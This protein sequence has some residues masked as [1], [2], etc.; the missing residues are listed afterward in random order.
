ML[1]NEKKELSGLAFKTDDLFEAVDTLINSR[2]QKLEYDQTVEAKIVST[3]QKADGIYKVEY[4]SAIFDAYANDSS[5]YYA[6]EMVYVMIPKGDFTKQK[7]I[8]G[9]ITGKDTDDNTSKT[10]NFK[11]PFDNF[12]GLE[13]LMTNNPMIPVQYLANKPT[14]GLKNDVADAS[15]LNQLSGQN[16]DYTAAISAVEAKMRNLDLNLS[17]IKNMLK[18]KAVDRAGSTLNQYQYTSNQTLL[19]VLKTQIKILAGKYNETI[20]ENALDTYWTWFRNQRNIDVTIP[21]GDYDTLWT[22]ARSEHDRQYVILTGEYN[23]AVENARQAVN[24]LFNNSIY[25][26]SNSNHIW[27]WSRSSQNPVIETKLGIG[28]DFKVLLGNYRPA[29]GDYGLRI[30]ISGRTKPTEEKNSEEVTEEVY[31]K[32]SDMY[33][34]VYAFYE[35]YTQQKI[36]DI[37]H[38]V[39]LNRI[40]IFFWQ[41][42]NFIA[43]NGTYI[44]YQAGGKDLPANI[45][46]SGLDVKLG[47]TTDECQTDRVFLYTYDDVY[48]GY[49]P[50]EDTPRA[51]DE[52]ADRILNFAWVHIGPDGPV[53]VNHIDYYPANNTKDQAAL[54]YWIDNGGA[55]IQ[56]YHFEYG[57]AQDTT[58]L[59]ER[60][61]GASWKYL[62]GYNPKIEGKDYNGSQFS[63][64]VIP[65]IKKAKDKW[66]AV[67]SVG[68]VPYST[69]PLV[70]TNRDTRVESESFDSLNE[71][72]FRILHEEFSEQ[73]NEFN[74]VEDNQLRDFYVYDINGYAI[75]NE[76]NRLYSDIDYYLQVCIRNNDTGEY[77]PM[78]YDPDDGLVEVEFAWPRGRTMI[79]DWN[80]VTLEDLS[81]AE[82]APLL[83]GAS[84]QYN[85]RI[86]DITRKFHINN[87]WEAN[88]NNNT[89]SATVKRR[90]KTYHPSIQFNFGPSSSMGTDYVLTLSQTAPGGSM[91]VKDQQFTIEANVKQKAA[92]KDPNSK[93]VFSW[94]LLSPTVITQSG[95]ENWSQGQAPSWTVDNSNGFLGN[96]IQGYVRN[97]YPPIFKVTVRNAADYP[98]SQ[99]TGFRLA[100][101]ADIAA[102]YVVNSCTER[103]EFKSDGAVP[104]SYYGVFSVQVMKDDGTIADTWPEW[105]MSQM[106]KSGGNWTLLSSPDYFGLKETMTVARSMATNTNNVIYAAGTSNMPNLDGPFSSSATGAC[107]YPFVYQNI[108]NAINQTYDQTI[109]DAL[110]DNSSDIEQVKSDAEY[111]R[112]RRLNDLDLSASKQLPAYKSYQFEP[113]TKNETNAPTWMWED[114]LEKNYYTFIG[115]TVLEGYFKQAVPFTRN[116]YSSTLLNSWD[117]KLFLD[118]DNNAILSQMVSAGTKS[119]VDGTF[120]GV[121]MGNWAGVSDTSLDIPG[122]YGLKDGGQVFGF[123]TDGTGFIGKSGR[124]RIMFDGNQSLISNVDRTSYINLDPIRYHYDGNSIVFDD[125]KGYSQFFLYS[126][127]KKTSTAS[128]LGEDSL[129][130]STYWAKKYM[131]DTLKDYFIVDPNNGILTSGGV[132]ARYGKIGNW[133]ISE[134]GIYQK[135]T[136]PANSPITANRYMY[137]GYPGVSDSDIAAVKSAYA[138]AITSIETRRQLAIN[139]LTANYLM[140]AFQVIGEYYKN[141]FQLDPMHYFNY[142]WPYY[143]FIQAIQST[144]DVINNETP[145]TEVRQILE[146]NLKTYIEAETRSGYHRHYMVVNDEYEATEDTPYTGDSSIFNNF[147]VGMTIHEPYFYGEVLQQVADTNKYPEGSHRT[148]IFNN[149][150]ISNSVYYIPT[151]KALYLTTYYGNTWNS[152]Y[153][154]KWNAYSSNINTFNVNDS[155][156]FTIVHL[157]N[158]LSVA[159]GIYN[160]FLDAYTR[161]IQAGLEAGYA[162]LEEEQKAEYNK[163]K[164]K[165]LTRMDDELQKLNAKYDELLT[166]INN[167]INKAVKALY[168]ADKNRYAIYAGYNPPNQVGGVDPLFTVNWRGYMTARAGKIG[169][170]SPWY[171]SDEGLTQKNNSGTIFLGN[172]NSRSD[173]RGWTDLGLSNDMDNLSEILL[174]N[175]AAIT[176]DANGNN[177]DLRGPAVF[178][179][180]DRGQFAIYAGG[181][182]KV[183]SYDS[184][185]KK[186]M[187]NNETKPTIKFGVRMDGTLYASRG[188]VGGWYIANNML[189]A[190]SPDGSGDFLVLD[191]V[192]GVINLNNAIILEKT[193]VVTLG[194]MVDDGEG[195]LVSSGTINIAGV[196]FKGRNSGQV[197]FSV[198]TYA[199]TASGFG[200]DEISIGTAYNFWGSRMTIG[201]ATISAGQG[202]SVTAAK[203]IN[204]TALLDINDGAATS[205]GVIIGFGTEETNNNKAVAIYPSVE[206]ALTNSVLGTDK[207][208]WDIIGDYVTCNTLDVTQG[209]ISAL[210]MFMGTDSA[211]VATQKWVRAQL[212]DVYAAI[213]DAAQGGSDAGQRSYR[214]ATNLASSINKMIDAIVTFLEGKYFVDTYANTETGAI[215]WDYETS[216]FPRLMMRVKQIT[217]AEDG[218]PVYISDS[219]DPSDDIEGALNTLGLSSE[220]V[221]LASCFI[222][223]N[224]VK[225]AGNNLGGYDGV[226]YSNKSIQTGLVRQI[227]FAEDYGNNAFASAK[228]VDSAT[229][230]VTVPFAVYMDASEANQYAKFSID[231]NHSHQ[232]TITWDDTTG[233]IKISIDNAN[234]Q[235]T[236]LTTDDDQSTLTIST[237]SWFQAR[238]IGTLYGKN[239]YGNDVAVAARVVTSTQASQITSTKVYGTY[240]SQSTTASISVPLT[241]KALDST[242]VLIEGDLTVDAAQAY[243]QGW[244]DAAN[245]LSWYKSGK[246]LY[247]NKPQ[248]Y[249]SVPSYYG[250]RTTSKQIAS[251]SVELDTTYDSACDTYDAESVQG[252]YSDVYT[253]SAYPSSTAGKYQYWNGTKWVTTDDQHDFYA[254]GTTYTTAY[255]HGYITIND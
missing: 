99:T 252:S 6:N 200:N 28:I 3:T 175:D 29:S 80:E 198:P 125:Y 105:T 91:L 204:F 219:T 11:L 9:R 253:G 46:L 250:Y 222:V 33:G 59:A 240:N 168:D 167:L 133:L 137:L 77:L 161:Q 27:S 238:G 165:I 189:Y 255:A 148:V 86:K 30:L 210:N 232:P 110:E 242:T 119:T 153:N 166:P 231:L 170:T 241:L 94:E 107:P 186:W 145:W 171:I 113:Y 221:T 47:L 92:A 118:E 214:G 157:Q 199:L 220:D 227:S 115:F 190:G 15:F 111:V 139:T 8:V 180:N 152:E 239:T 75:K 84:E 131:D 63:I 177:Q 121:V 68:N 38:F 149:D 224:L 208:R 172:P 211:L 158:V 108:Y 201:E 101:N 32:T 138:D 1:D 35:P 26:T 117:G 54:Q 40:D 217:K 41:D 160:Y 187:S 147:M 82:L 83:A 126:E 128:L 143:S 178:G 96:V 124:G 52:K 53:L 207:H 24:D 36:F 228:T 123:K 81:R 104:I 93:Y 173:G 78:T 215:A 69:E 25:N 87:L 79:R 95:N 57:C 60:Q 216:D 76:N 134:S 185:S 70:F 246:S 97:D 74:I 229:N 31:L 169:T 112:T 245:A 14:D 64:S 61:G 248:V 106:R 176:Q 90:G 235:K 16:A 2:I 37:S 244:N 212:Q 162:Q 43:Q 19:E 72:V 85:Q 223:S 132:I 66:K 213:Q 122:L 120:T 58:Q 21:N 150:F 155:A 50:L 230:L 159:T 42:H 237:T 236:S 182:G 129:E 62:G 184:E 203:K 202:T 188:L 49:D 109:A 179:D 34:N 142:G 141:I 251:F 225:R 98:I 196:V 226:P 163:Q 55:Q 144:L 254:S 67:V 73:A 234:F 140:E 181:L 65:D 135:Y 192:N 233:T 39:T 5:S 71:V 127:A 102:K 22:I 136:A 194:T 12:V 146:T 44:P 151:D 89:V 7:Y 193:G 10:F 114:K 48:Y 4:Q 20:L 174:P 56:W 100:Q 206:S 130:E 116:V 17:A 103:V 218:K 197:D 51:A 88:K 195:G 18:D 243:L 183:W 156:T 209:N 205:N 154:T 23:T 191:A 164:A 13:N 249:T 45:L 247:I